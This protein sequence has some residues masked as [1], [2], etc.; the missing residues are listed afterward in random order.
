MAGRVAVVTVVLTLCA[1]IA[2]ADDLSRAEQL[3]WDKRFAESEALYRAIVEKTPSRRARLGLARVLMWSG[4]YAEAITRFDALL[5]ENAKDVDALEGRATAGYWSGDHRSAA[6]DF[7]RVLQLDSKRET[8]RSSL[9]EIASTMR[10]SQRIVFGGIRDDQPLDVNRGELSATFFS[11]PVTRW[12]ID[13]GAMSFDADRRGTRT[14]EF[15]R[16]EGDTRW[17]AFGLSGSVGAFDGDFIGHASVRRSYFVLR[18]E[19][20]PELASAP[21]I[22][23]GAFSTTTTLRW[24]RDREHV[25]AAAEVS[26]RRYSD[27]NNAQTL[28]AYAVVPAYKR[29]GWT[30]WTGASAAARDTAESR[31]QPTAVSS[32]FEGGVF[33]YTYRGE[34]DP[35]WTPD[36]LLEGRIVLA[37]ERELGRARLKA[38]A[39]GGYAQDRGR[40]FGPDS[41]ATPLPL[42]TYTF[43][44]D[45]Q[46][47][48]YR[49][50][51]T[52]EMALTSSL[53]LDIGV[54]RSVTVDY[55]S[56]SIHAAVA[57]RR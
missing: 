25:I 54:E 17:R 51:L 55:R 44:F 26:D 32:S 21:A 12:T 18:V 52:A 56:T 35:Y 8:A 47:N 1:A 2:L 29:S 31:F 28:I 20:Q 37:L 45:R 46:Y 3:A 33:H 6:R 42:Q 27:D 49:L 30:L 24:H 15:V 5:S 4:H 19:R 57:R 23:A 36:N 34:Y 7:R 9:A 22:R 40:A 38:H 50:G 48:P 11:D 41:G 16:F 43:A 13:V 39:D 53:R 10:T 14:A